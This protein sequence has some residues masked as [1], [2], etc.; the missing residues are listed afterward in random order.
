MDCSLKVI[1]KEEP[2]GEEENSAT[3]IYITVS[4]VEREQRAGISNRKEAAGRRSTQNSHLH[5]LFTAV[6]HNIKISPLGKPL[7]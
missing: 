7:H 4:W 6:E 3:G 2:D 5:T 1:L